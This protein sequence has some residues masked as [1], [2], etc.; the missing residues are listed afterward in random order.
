MGSV[1]TMGGLFGWE[2]FDVFVVDFFLGEHQLIGRRF[3][4]FFS[5]NVFPSRNLSSI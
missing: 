1:E 4:C 2:M 3:K 5:G